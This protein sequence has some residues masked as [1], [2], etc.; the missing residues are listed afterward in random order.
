MIPVD[1]DMQGKLPQELQYLMDNA[2]SIDQAEPTAITSQLL[3]DIDTI[4]QT[5]LKKENPDNAVILRA[6]L[7]MQNV[8]IENKELRKR[9][10]KLVG[11]IINSEL[12]RY[13]ATSPFMTDF[14]RQAV[15]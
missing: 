2:P 3:Q 4:F 12:R 14:R 6:F 5:L 1:S 7:Q 11:Q 15:S 9:T 10:D 13:N 8:I